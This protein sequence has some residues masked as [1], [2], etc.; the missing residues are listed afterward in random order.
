M[1]DADAT[2]MSSAEAAMLTRDRAQ[3]T[4]S[5]SFG[6]NGNSG[7]GGSRRGAKTVSGGWRLA[8]ALLLA[9]AC[10]LIGG[11]IAVDRDDLD[12]APALLWVRPRSSIGDRARGQGH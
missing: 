2:V 1:A 4:A 7:G 11:A 5:S 9:A 12:F 10:A 3:S 6:G 8:S